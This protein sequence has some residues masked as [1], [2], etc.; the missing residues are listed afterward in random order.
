[1][2]YN[3]YNTQQ[4]LYSRGKSF[5]INNTNN[6]CITIA[7][8]MTIITIAKL[9]EPNLSRV[10]ERGHSEGRC[11]WPTAPTSSTHKQPSRRREEGQAAYPQVADTSWEG[12]GRKHLGQK[13]EMKPGELNLIFSGRSCVARNIDK[14]EQFNSIER[15]TLISSAYT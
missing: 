3:Y 15:Q 11:T 8:L 6:N 14:R 10:Q 2:Q 12:E 9:N 4:M 1:M 13:N 5:Y 7:A